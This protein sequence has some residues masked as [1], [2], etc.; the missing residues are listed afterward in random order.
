MMDVQSALLAA[1]VSGRLVLPEPAA[2]KQDIAAELRVM[3]RRYPSA[4]RYGLELDPRR[5]RKQVDELL[6]GAGG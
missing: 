5:Y 1:A 2:M 6:A 4:A 3:T